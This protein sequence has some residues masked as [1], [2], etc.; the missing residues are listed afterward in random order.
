MMRQ[1]VT[2]SII[3]NG[4][5]ADLYKTWLDFTNHPR[6]MEHI[7]TVSPQDAETAHWVMDGPLNTK[8]E[9]TTKTT[10]LEPNKRIAWKTIE[11]DLKSSGQVTFNSLPRGQTEVTVTA[12]TIPPDD[13]IDKVSLVLFENEGVQLERDLRRFKALI[14]NRSV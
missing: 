9:W 1:Q 4:E 8:L 12:Q 5:A 7:T 13:L 3:V 11:G 6:F 14:E 2:K 10:R